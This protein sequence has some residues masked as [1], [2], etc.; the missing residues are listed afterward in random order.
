[1]RPCACTTGFVFVK[2]GYLF[3]DSGRFQWLRIYKTC[4]VCKG[5]GYLEEDPFNGNRLFRELQCQF[6]G[7]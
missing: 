2:I 1:M 5:M 3:C 4:P 7:S 6:S